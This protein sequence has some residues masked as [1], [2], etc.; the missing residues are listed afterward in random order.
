MFFGWFKLTMSYRPGSRNGKPVALSQYLDEE[1]ED[2][3]PK[4]ILL[5]SCVVTGITWKIMDEVQATQQAQPDPGNGPPGKL[6]VPSIVKTKVL[7]WV[8]M[9]KLACHPCHPTAEILVIVHG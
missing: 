3:A 9:S 4:T 1:K 6:F 2:S 8:Q 7:Q 5:T